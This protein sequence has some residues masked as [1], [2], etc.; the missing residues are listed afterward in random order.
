MTAPIRH[1]P[2]IRSLPAFLRNVLKDSLELGP[3]LERE[4][5]ARE[6]AHW[7]LRQSWVMRMTAQSPPM[8]EPLPVSLAQCPRG[9]HPARLVRSWPLRSALAMPVVP[10]ASVAQL[11]R[12]AALP[13]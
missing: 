4:P 6:P 5:R 13:L 2:T 10:Q 12:A 11:A 1:T 3:A 7:L 9:H 8:L